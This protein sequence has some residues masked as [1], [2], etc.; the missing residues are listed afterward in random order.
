MDPSQPPQNQ[1]P[2]GA[3]TNFTV[4]LAH[5]TEEMY[6]KNYELAEKNKT[7]SLLRKIDAI[8][9][10]AVTNINE[11]SK[12]VVNVIAG[13]T[14]LKSLAIYIFDKDGN[15][16]VKLAVSETE[17]ITNIE[18][19][20]NKSLYNGKIFLTD[21]INL[22]ARAAAEKKGQI[23]HTLF[24]ILTP[25][26]TQDETTLA[27]S[28][29][30][31]Q[32]SLIYPLTVR[33]NVIGVLVFGISEDEK[34]LSTYRRDLIERLAEVIGISID[35]SLLYQEIQSA[36]EKLQQLDKLKDE[37][38]SLAS[39]ELRTP[40][41]A[42]KSYLWMA[43]MGKGGQLSEKQ[44]YY[45][46]RA[47]TSTNRLIKLVNDMLN[48]SRI[49][50]G[51]ISLSMVS[52]NLEKL[53][54]DVIIEIT[55]RAQE[56]GIHIVFTPSNTIPSVLADP[57]KIKE[58]LI[59]LIGNS[60][61]F[62]PKDGSIT[63]TVSQENGMVITRVKD[64]GAGIK[65]EDMAKLFHKFSMVG[66]DYLRKQNAQG[67]GLGLYISKSLIELHGGKIIAT[68]DGENTGT[69]FSFSLK[70]FENP[71]VGP[72]ATQPAVA[73]ATSPLISQPAA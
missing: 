36:N 47:Y 38:V 56:L 6:K 26:L 66:S 5:I 31:I 72:T 10:S 58:V 62:T 21:T 14:D 45:L 13:D 61:K 41:T 1:P 52:T 51:R 69:T 64:T 4:E 9:L 11:T 33:G 37:F 57:D 68:S 8:T 19:Q 18:K 35:N 42:I 49:E 29:L 73:Q 23:T 17:A 30:G 71:V 34:T 3:D 48:V 50:S 27:Q 59:N 40:M 54:Q 20:L 2:T 12:Q 44:S 43:L 7:L 15:A 67:T 32:S 22:I 25:G 16:L 55:P 46:G 53:I 65:K 39:H 24:P 28:T 60:F 70:P 63:I